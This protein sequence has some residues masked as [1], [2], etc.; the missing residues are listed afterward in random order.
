MTHYDYDI[1]SIFLAESTI[2]SIDCTEY[3]NIKESSFEYFFQY[4]ISSQHAHN[5]VLNFFFKYVVCVEI[6]AIRQ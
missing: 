1:K 2:T 4:L 3:L 6:T 5:N